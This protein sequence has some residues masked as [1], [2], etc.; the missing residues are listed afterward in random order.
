MSEQ[1]EQ[2]LERRQQLSALMDGEADLHCTARLCAAWR[3]DVDARQTWHAWH[4]IGDVLRS[5]DL[6]STVPRDT[7]FVVSL[8]ARLGAEPVVIAPQ[9]TPPA[10]RAPRRAWGAAA[11]AAAGFAVVVGAVLVVNT[12][13]PPASAPV[14][15]Q[16]EAA[17]ARAALAPLPVVAPLAEPQV[18][19][20]D[21]NVIRDARLDRYLA[22]HKPVGRNPALATSSFGAARPVDGQANR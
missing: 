22:A 20:A 9:A 10:A 18:V 14:L 8:R 17:P 11:A 2:A 19:I 6:A 15:A 7:R 21:G 3:D 13:S 12:S 1:P 5:D 4:L 16:Q